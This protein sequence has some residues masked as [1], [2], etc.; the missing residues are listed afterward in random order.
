MTVWTEE[1]KQKPKFQIIFSLA[2]AELERGGG[3]VSPALFQNVKKSAL[4]FGEN[5]LARFIYGFHFSFK[6]LF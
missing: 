2:G 3:E 5:A 1:K 6:I 4:I